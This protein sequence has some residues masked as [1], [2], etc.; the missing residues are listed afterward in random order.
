MIATNSNACFGSKARPLTSASPTCT[1]R[2]ARAA[3]SANTAITAPAA[4]SGSHILASSGGDSA[5]A[6]TPNWA[7]VL[8]LDT[9]PAP[10]QAVASSGLRRAR[11]PMLAMVAVL[12]AKPP[13][14]PASSR[15]VRAPNTRRATWPAALMTMMI[16]ASSHSLRRFSTCHG[17]I[18]RSGSSGNTMVAAAASSRASCSS[19]SVST[20]RTKWWT[21]DFDA[22][23]KATATPSPAASTSSRIASTPSRNTTSIA[24]SVVR[25]GSRSR[26]AR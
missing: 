26:L 5:P 23:S 25:P 9:T 20:P 15:P 3:A 17:S 16:T 13:A 1:A 4:A 14:N 11:V 22:S 10:A 18:V 19:W 6:T 24:V 2:E 7:T 12:E 21:R 8:T